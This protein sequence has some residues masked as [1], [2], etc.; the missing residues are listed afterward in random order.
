M[1]YGV[2][3]GDAQGHIKELKVDGEVTQVLLGRYAGLNPKTLASQSKRNFALSCFL[4]AGLDK[5][6][7]MLGPVGEIE[8]DRT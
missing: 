6:D 2:R 5:L 3:Y 7:D 1:R 4:S 8:E